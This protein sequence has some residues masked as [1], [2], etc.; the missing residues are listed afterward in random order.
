MVESTNDHKNDN[1]SKINADLYKT[2]FENVTRNTRK[3]FLSY[4]MAPLDLET[5]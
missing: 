2:Q 4:N 5:Q 3:I 1:K